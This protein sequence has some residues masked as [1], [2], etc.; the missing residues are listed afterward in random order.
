LFAI[1]FLQKTHCCID[2]NSDSVSFY[3]GRVLLPLQ[4][5]QENSVVLRATKF[6]SIS[7]KS[8]AFVPIKMAKK[9]LSNFWTAAVVQQH[10]E[11]TL[12]N[13]SVARMLINKPQTKRIFCRVFNCD[14]QSK[15]I[16]RGVSVAVITPLSDESDSYCRG[17]A[18][19]NGL[20]RTNGSQQLQSAGAPHCS[21]GLLRRE[22][23]QENCQQ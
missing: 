19:A 10:V 15:N 22:K 16:L 14:T 17:Q 9:A 5:F 4:T 11:S 18:H 20:S 7:A 3:D 23:Q 1:D 2:F 6:I 21:R 12:N 8:K 13:V